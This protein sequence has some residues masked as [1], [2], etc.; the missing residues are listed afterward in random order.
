MPTAAVRISEPLPP[1]RPVSRRAVAC[2][3]APVLSLRREHGAGLVADVLGSRGEPLAETGG[4]CVQSGGAAQVDPGGGH[5]RDGDRH[6]RVVG[7]L[8]RFEPTGPPPIMSIATSSR[9]IGEFVA[10]TQRVAG[11]A[12]QQDAGRSIGAVFR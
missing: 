11:R 10:G 3:A 7:P 5:P 1:F 4:D 6:R 9:W 12:G 8:P 2:I